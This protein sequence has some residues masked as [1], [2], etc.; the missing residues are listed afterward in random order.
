MADVQPAPQRKLHNL[1]TQTPVYLQRTYYDCGALTHSHCDPPAHKE[2]NAENKKCTMSDLPQHGTARCAQ[3][4]SCHY[5]ACTLGAA[6][7]DDT[8]QHSTAQ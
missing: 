3:Q 1:A 2:T 7:A 6:N 4:R 8:P 5:N